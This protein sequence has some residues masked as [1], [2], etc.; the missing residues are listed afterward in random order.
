MVT[1]RKNLGGKFSVVRRVN[2]LDCG[3]LKHWGE[4]PVDSKHCGDGNAI[5]SNNS[6]EHSPQYGRYT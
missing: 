6:W 3:R 4:H 5:K 1:Q 2:V